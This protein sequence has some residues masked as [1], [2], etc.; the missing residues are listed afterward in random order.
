MNK[1]GT[2]SQIGFGCWQLGGGICIG[3]NPL[4]YGKPNEE[5]ARKAIHYAIENGINFFD[6]ADIYGIGKSETILGEEIKGKRDSIVICTKVGHTPDGINGTIVDL[7]Y[8]NIMACCER[9]LKRLQTNYIDIY[10]LYSMRTN[11]IFNN[12]SVLTIHKPTIYHIII[13][14][15]ILCHTTYDY[16]L[17]VHTL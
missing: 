1:I 14:K 11:R 9:S 7:S 15:P 5:E 6:T 2:V 10:L 3:D 13:H 17:I 8:H 4:G 12:I 16:L